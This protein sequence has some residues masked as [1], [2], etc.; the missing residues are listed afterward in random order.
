MEF[1]MKSQI[2]AEFFFNQHTAKNLHKTFH[3]IQ[4]GKRT[5]IVREGKTLF[6]REGEFLIRT[7]EATEKPFELTDIPLVLPP[8]A[9]DEKERRSA[10]AR[11]AVETRMKNKALLLNL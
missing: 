10:I 6:L 3:L 9:D 7:V 5:F 1:W 11:R 2:E 8:V 4:V